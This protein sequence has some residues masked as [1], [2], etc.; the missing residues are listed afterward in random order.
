MFKNNQDTTNNTEKSMNNT[1][2]NR[3]MRNRS[4]GGIG[5]SST[6]NEFFKTQHTWKTEGDEH[7]EDKIRSIYIEGGTDRQKNTGETSLFKKRI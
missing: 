6:S 2:I 1:H 5:M 3:F 4:E 7:D